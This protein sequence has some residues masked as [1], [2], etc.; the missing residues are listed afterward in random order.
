M[1]TLSASLNSSL[2][3]VGLSAAD[4]GQIAATKD[5]LDKSFN[6][7]STASTSEPEKKPEES[8]TTLSARARELSAAEQRQISELKRIDAQVR[9]HE[10]AHI[11]AG[12]GVVTSGP[13]YT[14]TYGPD[15]RQYAVAGEV[16]IDT[17]PEKKPEANIDKGQRIQNA[18]LAPSQ[19]SPQDYQIAAVGSQLES[20]GRSDLV[21]Q[22]RAEQAAEAAVAEAERAAQREAQAAEESTDAAAT[23]DTASI[24][25]V[26]PTPA[27]PA[28]ISNTPPPPTSAPDNGGEPRSRQ[29]DLLV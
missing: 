28:A 23:P 15:G 9:A 19:P 25:A 20:Q 14:Y 10:Q 8:T 11:S 12:R 29:V 5:T 4:A 24:P 18:A 22:I 17:S 21:E 6:K 2:A 1:T 3:S 7:S 26:T 27:E 13:N 16:G